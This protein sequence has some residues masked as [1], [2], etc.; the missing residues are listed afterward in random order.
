[1]TG[2]AHSAQDVTQA[3]FMELA[4]HS[5]RLKHHPVL[6]AWLHTTARNLAAKNVRAAV[7]RQKHEQDAAAMN[8]LLSTAPDASWEEIAPHLDLALGELSNS[9]RQLVLLRYFQKKSAAET[10]AVLG[11]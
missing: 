10:A 8:E 6:S 9:D 3:V 5:A 11:I 1:M 4:Q 7:R 2:E